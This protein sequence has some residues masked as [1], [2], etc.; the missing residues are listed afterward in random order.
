MAASARYFDGESPRSW[1]ATAEIVGEELEISEAVTGRPLARWP[2]FELRGLPGGD[3]EHATLARST[4]DERLDIVAPSLIKELRRRV[5]RFERPLPGPRRLRRT[6]LWM[7]GAIAAT[8]GILFVLVPMSADFLAPRVPVSAEAKLGDRVRGSLAN[9]GTMLMGEAPE[10]CI[11]PKGVRAL[12]VLTE[13]VQGDLDLPYDLEVEVWKSEIANALALPGGRVLFLDALIL[14]AEHPDEVA[15]VLAHEIGHVAARDGL[16]LTLRAAGSAGLI[17][18]V[19]GD[20]AGGAGSVLVAQQLLNASYTREAEA[21]ADQFA[22]DRL[23]A[24]AISS[25]PLGD[26]FRRLV[27]EV[28]SADTVFT[29]FET[30]PDLIERAE[31]AEAAALSPAEARPA[32]TEAQW[33]ALRAICSETAPID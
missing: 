9:F 22:F 11:E 2:L 15:G 27:P 19:L 1:I 13:R 20:F 4:G 17:S 16:R 26:F 23:E 10:V 8:A 12:D 31:R 32:L 29:H 30:H 25:A 21:A 24:A 18:V 5:R 14:D 28:A 6:A 33:L 3:A 7:A